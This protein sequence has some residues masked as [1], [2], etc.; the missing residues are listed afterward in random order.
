MVNL[1]YICPNRKY[2]YNVFTGDRILSDCGNCPVCNQKRN[3]R[4]FAILNDTC[5]QYA[6][7]LFVTLTYDN[8][9]LPTCK[10]LFK[11]DEIV[12]I[13]LSAR[14][15]DDDNAECY[16][17][18][19]KCVRND[20]NE[21]KVRDF[22]S[23]VDHDNRMLPDTFG[24]IYYKDVQYFFKRL[25]KRFRKDKGYS[26]Q[27][28]Y[29]VLCEYGGK[30]L[31]P[32][33]HIIIF[34]N[35]E[36]VRN[37]VEESKQVC[38]QCKSKFM[39][40]DWENGFVDCQRPNENG[41][42]AAYCSAY[43]SASSGN[44]A[45]L[46]GQK[47]TKQG[48][49][50]STGLCLDFFHSL[51]DNRQNYRLLSLED[52]KNLQYRKDDDVIFL[53]DSKRYISALFPLPPYVKPRSN[54]EFTKLY[55]TF[56]ETSDLDFESYFESC[57]SIPF[58]YDVILYFYRNLRSCKPDFSDA[59]IDA[60]VKNRVKQLRNWANSY[61]GYLTTDC[62]VNYDLV[63]KIYKLYDDFDSYRNQQY[64]AQLQTLIFSSKSLVDPDVDDCYSKM[65]FTNCNLRQVKN[66]VK[67]MHNDKVIK[68]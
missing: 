47:S 37:F 25:R 18:L 17:N 34:T 59:E 36:Q 33:Y 51:R 35:D 26:A 39:L 55:T 12:S 53:F 28:K 38:P 5:K 9:H 62:I 4:Y 40:K 10:V 11:D 64:F 48:Y 6:Y 42:V 52:I 15:F 2:V 44:L 50:H 68:F 61:T 45:F 23:K 27:F 67:K 19:V 46:D 58:G 13:P 41:M 66:K 65:A 49:K 24:V 21:S 60:L 54:S 22:L 32:H 1:K 14:L 3:D 30:Y 7:K 31:R 56:K 63:E 29:F 8:N 57:L 43:V 20:E 16:Y